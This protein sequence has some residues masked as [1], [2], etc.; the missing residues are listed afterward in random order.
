MNRILFVFIL[1]FPLCGTISAQMPAT[2]GTDFWVAFMKCYD[3]NY[4]DVYKIQIIAPNPCSATVS[5]PTTGWSQTVNI[6][7]GQ[8]NTITIPSNQAY[9]IGSCVVK[10]T[11]LYVV[12]T[13]SA[14]VFSMCKESD[15]NVCLMDA[16]A[17]F[18][19]QS[20]KNDYIVVDYPSH[21]ERCVA[22][23]SVL[24]TQD[25]TLVNIEY[26]GQTSS[27]IAAGTTETILLDSGQVYQ[28]IGN[29]N[30]SDFCGTHV[31]TLDCKPIAV[32]NGNSGAYIPENTGTSA[33]LL[34]NQAVPTQYWGKNFVL[35]AEKWHNHDYVR[36]TALKDSCQVMRNGILD[37]TLS[38]LQTY[39]F[40]YS[41][42]VYL[43]TSQPSMVV[44]FLGSHANCGTG[45][46]WG[47][48]SMFPVTPL[49]Q[50]SKD[51]PFGTFAL[52]SRGS[53]SSKY[54]LNVVVPSAETSLIT[55]DGSSL[56]SFAVV[57][58][59]PSYSYCRMTI[60][61]GDHHLTTTG[62]G[63]FA[64]TYGLGENWE[65]YA[66]PIG[67]NITPAISCDTIN[68]YQSQEFTLNTID[69]NS[70]NATM[71]ITP[72]LDSID[73]DSISLF[74][75]DTGTYIVRAIV[76]PI[77]DLRQIV[78]V[79]EFVIVIGQAPTLYDTVSICL[80][81]YEWN[82]NTYIESGD[83]S[84]QY[85]DSTGCVGEKWLHLEI[86]GIDTV[87]D[88]IYTCENQYVWHDQT[89]EVSNDY[90]YR[91]P[92]IDGCDDIESLH[93]FFCP[94]YSFTFDTAINFGESYTWIDGISYTESIST[95][96]S[97]VS[98]FGC[99]SIYNLNLSVRPLESEIYIPNVF[100]PEENTNKV[101]QVLGEGIISVE[102]VIYN[103]W[104][105]F[106][107]RW[108]GLA[109]YWDGTHDGIKCKSESYVY[110]VV[111]TDTQGKHD[112][113][114]GTVTLIR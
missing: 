39:E 76:H 73:A 65:S 43:E 38:A 71:W 94:S 32:F 19:I 92:G 74:L 11:G 51:A 5:N 21:G 91:F 81:P 12:T 53:Y 108:E 48:I 103:R 101:F 89:L 47:D 30:Q 9:S 63:F 8:S 102:V 56:S 98:Q 36:V 15:A 54:Y 75:S 96:Y 84:V 105:D 86:V 95:T 109:G 28:V 29:S 83:Y 4:T 111:Y 34:Y 82:G 110:K 55:L 2:K 113:K 69:T 87:F 90:E 50:M 114:F 6:M 17:V 35:T 22:L 16:T 42:A 79:H 107:Y 70:C 46:D 7:A 1:L 58:G 68:F 100:T 45:G 18:P 59:N 66:F 37:T 77:S 57:A 25:S 85:S 61:Q 60:S 112:V 10:N 14:Y 13:D 26:T 44:E 106:I 33:D 64:Y 49:S 27:G 104:G 78:G 99:D 3:D 93:L 72:N 20:L 97:L 80:P 40:D 41:D 62:S 31:R 67:M 24:A 88:T 52:R 23:F